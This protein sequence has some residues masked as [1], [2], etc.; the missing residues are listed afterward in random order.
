MTRSSATHSRRRD[1]GL[2]LPAG[3][4]AVLSGADLPESL[5]SLVPGADRAN[6][7]LLARWTVALDEAARYV[8]VPAVH[9]EL[10]VAELV[11]RLRQGLDRLPRVR[12]VP[13]PGPSST[14]VSFMLL[15]AAG[16]PMPKA[17]LVEIYNA[18]VRTPGVQIG[19]AVQISTT[20]AAALRF[21]VGATTVTRSIA[22][23][24]SPTEAGCRTAND[25][26]EVLGE[27]LPEWATV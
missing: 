3:F 11:T 15:D 16:E 10:F 21:A 4:R 19:Q 27:L 13:A 20:G 1:R 7:G 23:D 8:A 2:A 26:L 6:L 18:L 24:G 14:I 25:A 9:R 17:S 5:R 12:V 22:S